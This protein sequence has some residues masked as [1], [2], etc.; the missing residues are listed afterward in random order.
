MN[1]VILM[2]HLGSD[3]ELRLLTG[4]GAL[5]RMRLA[6]N[7]VYLDKNRERQ[8]RTEWHDVVLFGS[9]AEPLSRILSKGSGVLVEGSVRT[10]SWEKDGVR[11]YRTEIHARDLH[12]MG[13]RPRGASVVTP[14]PEPAQA[15]ADLPF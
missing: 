15:E 9:R 4:G 11:R 13:S 1:N 12:L 3:P 7:E 10:S 2:G 14:D 8:E 6:T 5:L